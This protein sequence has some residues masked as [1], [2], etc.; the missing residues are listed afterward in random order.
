MSTDPE[1]KPPSTSQVA[2]LAR[3]LPF[4]QALHEQTV[5]IVY[6][7]PAVLTPRS[8]LSFS[9]DVALLALTGVR[10]VVVHG[11]LPHIRT[12]SQPGLPEARAVHAARAVL[13]EVNLELVRLIGSHGVKALGVTGQDSGLMIAAAESDPALMSPVTQ[14]DEAAFGALRENGRVPVVMPLAPD[15]GGQ[16]RLLRPE[17][18]GSVIAQRTGAVTLV[19]MVERA[20]LRELGGDA[21]LYG[22]TELAQWL[23]D[24]P[25]SVAAPHVREALD[26]LAHGVQNVH[27]ADI[28]QPE[29]LVDALLTEE[30]SGVV[31]CRRGNADLLLET[32]RYFADTAYALRRDFSVE[33]KTIVRF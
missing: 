17:R 19:M 16:D 20:V 1:S 9:Q 33:R 2:K 6:A 24:H 18:L 12:S 13:A 15:D 8:R 30:G 7:G 11:G 23:A 28:A 4:M 3:A 5:V 14:F 25:R 27:L 22:L 32:R 26:A 29:S 31:L 10:P 21:S